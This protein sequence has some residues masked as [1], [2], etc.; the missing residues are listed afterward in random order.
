MLFEHW[1]VRLIS[2][3]A[4][5]HSANQLLAS[6]CR[7]RLKAAGVAGGCGLEACFPAPSSN[8]SRSYILSKFHH[9]VKQGSVVQPWYAPVGKANY[10][11]R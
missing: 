8:N 1:P 10:C 5:T 6:R 11:G 7:C 4:S 2:C 3:L 9:V